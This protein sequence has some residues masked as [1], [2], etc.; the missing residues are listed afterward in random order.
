ME[1]SHFDDLLAAARA[2]PEP[3]RLLLV[4]TG[5]SLP[6]D[7][8]AEQRGRFDAGEAGELAPLMCVDKDP[9]ALADF[10]ALVG[11]AAELGPHWAL[12]FAAALPGRGGQP[13]TDSQVDAALQRMV[14]AVKSGGVGGLIP[15]DREGHAVH[16]S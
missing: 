15:F 1:I 8:T 9:R 3:Q 12:V 10:A 7:A 16:L 14:E 6:A 11:E 5:A 4:F 13:P 2:Q